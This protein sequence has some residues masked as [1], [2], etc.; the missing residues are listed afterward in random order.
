MASEIAIEIC[1]DSAESAMAAQ[2]GGADRIELC[3]DLLEGGITP[4]AG[5]IELVRGELSIPLHVMVRPRGGDFF[6]SD[7]EFRIMRRDIEVAKGLHANGVV[8]GILDVYGNVDIERTRKLVEQ[9]RPLSVTFHRAF[10]MAADLP[11]ALEDVC[12]TGADRI[13]TSGGE[14]TAIQGAQAIAEL[15]RRAEGRIVIMAGSGINAENVRRLIAETGVRE[16]HAGAS[17]VA[18]GPMQ[19][20]NPRIAM[21]SL[22]GRE[23]QRSLV[24]EEKVQKLRS[25][26]SAAE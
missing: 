10:D 17:V 7:A 16:I 1:V 13:L 6:Y 5:M 20:R 25:A 9:A 24:S 11:R 8:F 3:A 26:V 19:F 22:P 4:S 14:P 2:R 21:G 15:V 12:V 18:D 23:Y